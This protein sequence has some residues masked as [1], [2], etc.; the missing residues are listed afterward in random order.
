MQRSGRGYIACSKGPV[1]EAVVA[2]VDAWLADDAHWAALM[3]PWARWLSPA[4]FDAAVKS[5]V[6][7]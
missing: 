3:A 5:S 7:R 6:V 2:A 4:D 1:S